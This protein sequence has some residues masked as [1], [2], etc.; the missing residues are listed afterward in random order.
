MG[1]MFRS[2]EMALCQMFLQPEAAYSTVSDLGELGL[3]Q[4]RDVSFQKKSTIF[5]WLA[6]W[7][8]YFGIILILLKF[9]LLKLSWQ[10][11]WFLNRV[12]FTK[13]LKIVENH[14]PLI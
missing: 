13:F 5:K 11:T 4:F 2:E 14:S 9:F 12:I 8:D 3:V 7:H 6:D 1:S 10:V